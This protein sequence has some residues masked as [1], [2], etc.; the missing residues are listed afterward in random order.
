MKELDRGGLLLPAM[1]EFRLDVAIE[2]DGLPASDKC[3]M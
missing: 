2:L 3:T 1:P